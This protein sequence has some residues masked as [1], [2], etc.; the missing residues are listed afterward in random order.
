MAENLAQVS[1]EQAVQVYRACS[2]NS[3]RK[4]I[5]AAVTAATPGSLNRRST[6]IARLTQEIYKTTS[7][8]YAGVLT[9]NRGGKVKG[10]PDRFE[11]ITL[12]PG[13]MAKAALMPEAVVNPCPTKPWLD[14]CRYLWFV[15][16]M[17]DALSNGVPFEFLKTEIVDVAASKNGQRHV[18][19][20]LTKRA[21]RMAKFCRWL[22]VRGIPW[23][24]NLIPM[25]SVLERNMAG[26]INYLLDI[27]A[28]VRG[29]SVEPLLEAVDLDLRGFGWAIVGGESGP[30]SRPFDLAWARGLREQCHL[31]SIPFFAKQLG[32][33][34]IENGQ[35]LVL[36]DGHGGDWS[37]W[38]EDLRVRE[39]PTA[40]RR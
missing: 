37:E 31:A 24:A 16:D 32:S 26:Q 38:P 28:T 40:F 19:L 22:E 17:G 4:R 8:C 11:Q 9:D 10:Y 6:R 35:P 39:V 15:N 30:L 20:W 33:N 18:W 27:P 23:P 12:F 25:T 14:G 21:K 5:L 7:S 29:L 34:P 3:R 2:E 13:R 1:V 36:K